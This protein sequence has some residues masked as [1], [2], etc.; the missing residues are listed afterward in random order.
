MPTIIRNIDN[1][2]NILFQDDFNRTDGSIGS[3]YQIASGSTNLMTISSNTITTPSGRQLNCISTGSILFPPDQ[4]AELTYTNLQNF[5][6]FAA[7]VRVNPTNGTAYS[8]RVMPEVNVVQLITV[9][10]TNFNIITG[11]T[12][13]TSV[14]DIW[15]I[16]AAG[17]IISAYYN[18]LRLISVT[19]STY[20]SGQPG[21][22]YLPDNIRNTRC[23]N[24]KARNVRNTFTITSTGNRGRVIGQST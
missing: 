8:L 10:G 5:D 1:T 17:N 22:W 9:V 4:E 23:D 3:N 13:R 12:Q 15:T 16:R 14:G 6:Y 21:M 24:F 2:A 7:A 19:D 20:T 11:I 18:G